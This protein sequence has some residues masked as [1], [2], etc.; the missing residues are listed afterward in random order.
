[1]SSC[2]SGEGVGHL[3][4]PPPSLEEA[5]ENCLRNLCDKAPML[6]QGVVLFWL[7][8][9]VL[10]FLHMNCCEKIMVR[11]VHWASKVVLVVKNPLVNAGDARDVGSVPK[12]GRFPEIGNGNTLQY[13]CLENSID[14]G[15]WQATVHG[16]AKS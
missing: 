5:Y 1:M 9:G 16:A 3:V 11:N 4:H 12:E 2:L 15:A 13:S 10:L 6:V 8:W 7:I 14:R